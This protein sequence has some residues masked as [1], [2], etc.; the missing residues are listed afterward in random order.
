MI[1]NARPLYNC[2]LLSGF[3]VA[4]VEY[5]PDR[6]NGKCIVRYGGAHSDMSLQ[7]NL[8]DG[9]KEGE[10]LILRDNGTPFMSLQFVH[11][12]LDGEV[13]QFDE[14]GSLILKGSLKNGKE[15]DV[16]TEYDGGKIIWMGFYIYGHRHITLTKS[17]R[18]D[19]YYEE[20][21]RTGELIGLSH[22]DVI[23]VCRDGLSYKF[24]DGKV[25]RVCTYRDGVFERVVMEMNGDTL[26][27]YD[28]SG[29]KIYEGGFSG[30]V[31][32]GF[33][34]DERRTRPA[35]DGDA[36]M[37]N[38][39]ANSQQT[40]DIESQDSPST[41][42]G[43]WKNAVEGV[44]GMKVLSLKKGGSFKWP[45]WGNWA[46]IAVVVLVVIIVIIS[47]SSRKSTPEVTVTSC[48]QWESI[49][50]KRNSYQKVVIDS[51]LDCSSFDLSKF[52]SLQTLEVGDNCMEPVRS[53]QLDGMESLETIVIGKKSFTIAKDLEMAESSNRTDGVF[54][55]NNCPKLKIVK[56]NTYA[57]ADYR[58][59]EISNL[60]SLESIQFGDSSFHWGTSMT[61]ASLI[62]CEVR[63]RFPAAPNRE[64]QGSRVP[65]LS[66]SFV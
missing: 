53:F 54:R 39:G 62:G 59:F 13:K 11:D 65:W 45:S 44:K 57:F 18:M 28:E 1:A 6:L 60:P 42:Q 31:E 55:V 4:T 12:S 46:L 49:S 25:S 24:K 36:T 51:K 30:S 48:K 5:P 37:Y 63:R 22:F 64:V 8:Q 43:F 3:E 2:S 61:L 52:K 66:D 7:V 20:R 10:G 14:S 15:L 16:F 56:L 35:G 19:G 23:K 34:R 41:F 47:A 21:S 9:K 40:I 29:N 27:E 17:E 26:V 33:R 32:T 58:T 38:G 50:K